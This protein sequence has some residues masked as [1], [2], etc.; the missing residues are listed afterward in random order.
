MN[1]NF[2]NNKSVANYV[3]CYFEIGEAPHKS[4]NF[5]ERIVLSFLKTKNIMYFEELFPFTQFKNKDEKFKLS[6]FSI[7]KPF[8]VIYLFKPYFVPMGSEFK[9]NKNLCRKLGREKSIEEKILD[10]H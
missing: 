6:N 10:L 8:E 9:E 1:S 7:S 2:Q 5:Y 3:E 4:V